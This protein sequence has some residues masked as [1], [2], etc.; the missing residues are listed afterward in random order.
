[1][2]CGFPAISPKWQE[3]KQKLK[4]VD[5]AKRWVAPIR[6]LQLKNGGGT[7]MKLARL[8]SKGGGTSAM[9][10]ARVS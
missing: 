9:S 1:M 8:G 10:A 6:L 3:V 4:A 2:G 5:G 7:F